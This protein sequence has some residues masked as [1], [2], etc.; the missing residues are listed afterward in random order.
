MEKIFYKDDPNRDLL[1]IYPM[2]IGI[3]HK[4][5]AISR[6]KGAFTHH[7]LFIMDGEGI[8]EISDRTYILKKGTAV[9]IKSNTP[10]NYRKNSSVFKTA[11]LT[12]NGASVENILKYFS[13]DSF[14]YCDSGSIYPQFVSL[15]KM[16]ENNVSYADLSKA[17]YNCVISYFSCLNISKYP[18]PLSIAKKYISENYSHDISINNIAKAA[19]ISPSFLF[20][21]FNE[22]EQTTP[23]EYLKQIRMENAKYYLMTESN[24]SVKD[25]GVR[26]GYIDSSYFCKVFK[27]E[28]GIT[29]K[30]FK[31]IYKI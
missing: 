23:I 19:G 16:C 6:P 22:T 1:P 10:I 25:I 12:F 2:T 4:Q 7:I 14:S 18:T 13:A 20:R 28:T 11:W 30:K 17:V 3:E 8:F 9:Y 24:S 31:E 15:I 29:P 27:N 21:L 26:C 5:E